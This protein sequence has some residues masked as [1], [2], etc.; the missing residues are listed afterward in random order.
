MLLSSSSYKSWY[1]LDRNLTPPE[2]FPSVRT[3]PLS[4]FSNFLLFI[5]LKVPLVYILISSSPPAIH[6]AVL[7]FC[8]LFIFCASP[9]SSSSSFFC[10]QTDS[11]SDAT[12]YTFSPPVPRFLH[13]PFVSRPDSL[14]GKPSPPLS[15]WVS[16]FP[17]HPDCPKSLP[18]LCQTNGQCADS[19]IQ[20][21]LD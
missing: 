11:L 2:S 1:L 10:S 4:D 3:S 5:F 9:H 21:R 19:H 13:S 14:E 8:L 16:T 20:Y 12:W 17:L 18:Y 15:H 6:S 7:S